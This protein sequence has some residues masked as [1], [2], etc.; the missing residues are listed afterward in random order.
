VPLLL[1]DAA[2]H[3]LDLSVQAPQVIVRPSLEGVEDLRVDAEQE[4][5]ARQRNLS[6]GACRR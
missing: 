3:E 1:Q 4:G 2:Q 5:F 6:G